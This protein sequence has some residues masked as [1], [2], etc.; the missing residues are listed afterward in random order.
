[1]GVP[2][3]RLGRATEIERIFQPC[4]PDLTEKT[5][6]YTLQL[7]SLFSFDKSLQLI[8]KIHAT[9]KVVI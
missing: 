7:L 2:P 3:P 5:D 9:Y 1:M 4:T 6:Y 8:L